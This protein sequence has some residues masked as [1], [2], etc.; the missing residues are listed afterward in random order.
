MIDAARTVKRHWD[1]ILRWFDSKIGL[2]ADR[3]C[4]DGFIQVLSQHP[5]ATLA[6]QAALARA[7]PLWLVVP[8]GPLPYDSGTPEL[9]GGFAGT[10]E[11]S[12]GF[13]G[14]PELCGGFAGTPS[15]VSNCATCAVSAWICAH[16]ARVN[17][18]VLLVMR[19]ATEVGELGYPSLNRE[20]SD[21]GG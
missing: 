12:G 16:S 17:S 5:S 8:V 13:A 2:A 11:L 15:F 19:Q 10:P 4:D 6:T 9:S 1:G 18:N 14:T 21:P 3:A 7:Y 20:P